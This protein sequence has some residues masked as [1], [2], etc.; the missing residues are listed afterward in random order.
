MMHP[1]PFNVDEDMA[2]VKQW[3]DAR[4]QPVELRAMVSNHG[5]I[6]TDV[7]AAWLYLTDGP[8]ALIEIPISNPEASAKEVHDGF[9]ALFKELTKQ[10]INRGSEIVVAS[11]KV[12]G[13][14]KVLKR[15]GFLEA[16]TP[17]MRY[18]YGENRDGRT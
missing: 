5:M 10:A 15:V 14:G 13:V 17:I 2:T 18:F 3:W 12:G 11:P 7:C 1:R 8:F 9:C 16:G 4:E 6:V